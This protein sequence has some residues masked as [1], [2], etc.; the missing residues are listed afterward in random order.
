MS[1]EKM[2]WDDFEVG[3]TIGYDENWDGRNTGRIVEHVLTEISLSD[4]KKWEKKE[5]RHNMRII[6]KRDDQT[7]L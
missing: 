2:F 7:N 3:D 4:I 5:N 1:K 6:K